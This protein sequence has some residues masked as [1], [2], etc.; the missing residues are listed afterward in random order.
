MCSK[1]PVLSIIAFALCVAQAS[2]ANES[3]D[4]AVSSTE[5]I[6]LFISSKPQNNSHQFLSFCLWFEQQ[7]SS[8]LKSKG[9]ALL[10][11]SSQSTGVLKNHHHVPSF[12]MDH[13]PLLWTLGVVAILCTILYGLNKKSK[14]SFLNFDWE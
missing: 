11:G 7:R 9:K 12:V 4:E 2:V 14:F 10:N 5:S 1:R 8:F 3:A 13:L 6:A